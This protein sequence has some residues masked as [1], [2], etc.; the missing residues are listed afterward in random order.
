M[1]KKSN[2]VK[3]KNDLVEA[4]IKKNNLT[5][6]KIIFYLAYDTNRE[7]LQDSELI[8]ITMNTKNICKYC[9]VDI[10]T[11]KRNLK[12]MTETSINITDKKSEG[13]ITIIPKIK[14]NYNG[15]IELTM[16]KEILELIVNVKNKYTLVNAEQLMNLK[17]KH[18]ARMLILLERINSFSDNVAKRK[19]YTLEELNKLFGTNYKKLSEFERKILKP[20]QEDL[21]N[22]SVLSFLY[23]V[24]FDKEEISKGRPKAVG[25]VINL[26]NNTP[27]PTLF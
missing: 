10:K 4:F 9:N 13:Y 17:S 18:S 15:T 1:A 25:V 6:L 26:I 11:L 22:N 23:S 3:V 20:V 2:I 14:I 7:E 5:A 24:K 16:F 12:Q 8:K 27:H 19:H 21:N